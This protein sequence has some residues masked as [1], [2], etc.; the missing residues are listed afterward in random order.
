MLMVLKEKKQRSLASQER[1]KRKSPHEKQYCP[2]RLS[3]EPNQVARS[4]ILLNKVYASVIFKCKKPECRCRTIQAL[5][6]FLF[7]LE[8]FLMLVSFCNNDYFS[9][10][11]W[12][13]TNDL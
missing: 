13:R 1:N 12:T 10:G 7:L 11:Y 9:C 3:I 4:N 6:A 2:I 5:G 8:R